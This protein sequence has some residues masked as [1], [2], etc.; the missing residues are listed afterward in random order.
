MNDH[1]IGILG[2]GIGL[3]EK[4]LTN[5]DFEQLV[6]TTDEW[7][8]S[9]T[10][11]KERRILEEG[12][13]PTDIALIAAR[14]AIEDSGV[15]PEEIGAIIYATYIPD[16]QM[17]PSSA[18]LQAK[19]GLPSCM[20]F[21]LNGAC[22]GFVYGLQ[23]AHS[24]IRAGQMKK[25]LVVGCDC[26][27]RVVDYSDRA[28]CVLFGDGAGAAIVGETTNGSGI[29][30]TH[31][32]ADGSGAYFIFQKIG[33]GAHP[34]TPDNIMD[35]DRFMKMNGREVFKFAVRI[36]NE[37]VLKALE[38][39]GLTV[40]DVD[41]FVPHQANVRIINAAMERFGFERERVVIN[42]DMFGNTSA[43]SIPLA[44]NTAR[45]DGRLTKGKTCVL[46]AFGAG[47]TYAATVLKW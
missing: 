19:L 22:T 15:D 5:K 46:V 11:I 28:T 6:D 37:A 2:L 10:G 14:Q 27:S 7:I 25:I 42:M 1:P 31:A 8:T 29:L 26:N 41:L 45:E 33:A 20:T 17:P 9:R 23:V 12:R 3:P 36:F 44:L 13:A 16:H 35:P 40:E 18:L 34:I 24:M 32:G 4:R 38:D 39:A 47:L 43:A 30:G 21:D